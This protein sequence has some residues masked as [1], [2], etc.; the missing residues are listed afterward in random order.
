MFPPPFVLASAI[1]DT[2]PLFSSL[3]KYGIT[4]W[5]ELSQA[6][7]VVGALLAALVFIYQFRETIL[8][9]SVEQRRTQAA[10]ARELLANLFSDPRSRDALRMLDYGARTYLVGGSSTSIS[11][12]D[13]KNGL[14]ITPQ[15]PHKRPGEADDETVLRFSP[16]E[17]YVRDCFESLF[18]QVD[19]LEHFVQRELLDPDD[20]RPPLAYYAK[21]INADTQTFSV[22]LKQYEYE[23]SRAFLLR[24]TN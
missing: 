13:V 24:F 9:R 2:A 16:D 21:K 5:S 7:G 22:F 12:G 1:L 19:I 23:L 10:L 20:L 15:R 4:D 3:S 18:D 14:R 17:L 6:I 11:A 8:Q